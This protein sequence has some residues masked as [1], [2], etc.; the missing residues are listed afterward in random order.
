[1]QIKKPIDIFLTHDWPRNIYNY[2][3]TAQLLARKQFFREEVCGG[4]GGLYGM[5]G[6]GGGGR[7]GEGVNGQTRAHSCSLVF[8][9][10]RG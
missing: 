7:R 5:K 10:V 4:G 2:G 3:N 9:Q 6:M 8:W 1:M